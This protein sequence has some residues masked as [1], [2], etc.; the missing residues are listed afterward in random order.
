MNIRILL[1]GQK[2]LLQGGILEVP[3]DPLCIESYVYVPFGAPVR[4]GI[5]LGG[6]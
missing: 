6:L 3:E 5:T 2:G 1:L 4:A